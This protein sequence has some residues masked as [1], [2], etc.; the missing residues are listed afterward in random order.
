MILQSK[1]AA[2]YSTVTSNDITD[3]L[4][5]RRY[6]TKDPDGRIVE[7]P[8][9][10][11]R[12][13]AETIAAVESQYGASTKDIQRQVLIWYDLMAGGKFLPNTPT[14]VNAGKPDG[15]LSACFVLHIGDSIVEIH[16]ALAHMTVIQK[17]GG[18]TGF[19]FDE[20]RPSGDFVASS[21]GTTT[22]PLFF[23]GV[24]DVATGAIQQ[25]SHR[26]G[27]NMAL[28]NISHPDILMFI[29]AKRNTLS[30]NNFNIS[31][32][33]D[34]A[35]MHK[36]M[37]NRDAAHIVENP[38]DKKRYVIPRTVSPTS[39]RL[40]DLRSIEPNTE[41]CYTVG[42]VWDMIVA[43]AHEMGEPGLCFI[44]R[45]NQDN[46]TPHIGRIN[47]TNPCGEQP[48]LNGEGCNLGSLNIS[49]YVRPDGSDLDWPQ[50]QK[51][52]SQGVRFLDNVID[53]NAWPL[54]HVRQISCGNRKIGLGI[55]GL[56]DALVLLGLQ[57]NSDEAIA[58]VQKSG[59]FVREHAHRAS[60]RLAEERGNFPNW[61][62][63]V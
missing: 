14:L 25:G 23:M 31:V 60:Q 36:L 62:G 5:H 10:M 29:N 7:S 43:N 19:A 20:L 35:L 51:G 56:A 34:D 27:A 49:K 59:E 33:V 32:K 45:I 47:A 11:Y 63:S 50:L 18:G 42:D 2:P 15:Q 26:R 53:A 38:R 24:F 22:G 12:R 57:Y 21:G 46:P 30:L 13:V 8:E 61:E 1:I 9:Q 6:L 40:Q 41:D 48:L 52:V 55:M 37:N 16:E 4:L 3:V 58:F 44:D 17:S 54:D 28:M 39:Y